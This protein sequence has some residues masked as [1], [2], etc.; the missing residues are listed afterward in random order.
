M[1]KIHKALYQKRKYS[2]NTY[3]LKLYSLTSL[4]KIFLLIFLGGL[5]APLMTEYCRRLVIS[6]PCINY[7]NE[8]RFQGRTSYKKT[9]HV[10]FFSKLLT[11]FRVH[12]T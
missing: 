6:Q 12:R 1:K 7:L 2:L 11:V 9:I 4:Y 10:T 5:Q 3:T 8:L